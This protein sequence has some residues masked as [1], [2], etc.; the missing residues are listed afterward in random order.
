MNR[1]NAGIFVKAATVACALFG[2]AASADCIS[3]VCDQS[4]ILALY[5]RAD[6]DAFIQISG[7]MSV[8]T[9]NL[10]GGLYVKLPM[11]SP[12]FKEIYAS[13]LAYQLANRPVTVRMED[14]VSDCTISYIYST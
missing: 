9:C 5:T 10:V 4:Q 14:G 8:L 13:L 11:T 6:G 3:Y 7:N 1:S 2:S 12:R